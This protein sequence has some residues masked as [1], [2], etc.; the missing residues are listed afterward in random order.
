MNKQEA[1]KIVLE[2]LTN[3][4]CGLFVGKFDAKNGSK[5]F[6]YGVNMIMEYIAHKVSEE[7]FEEFETLFFDNMEK[8]IDKI[9]QE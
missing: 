5:D 6:M 7:E 8:S 9:E 1:F 2:D 3:S 4:G